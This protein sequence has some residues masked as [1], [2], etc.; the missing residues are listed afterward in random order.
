MC[1]IQESF[2]DCSAV[3]TSHNDNPIDL[4]YRSA[5]ASMTGHRVLTHG[6]DKHFL[7]TEK[8]NPLVF[9]WG[10]HAE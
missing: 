10:R 6:G 2:A 4:V 3:G 8:G 1:M 7:A 5:R 9:L